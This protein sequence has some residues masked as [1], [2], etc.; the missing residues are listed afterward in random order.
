MILSS[1]LLILAA[2]IWGGGFIATKWTFAAFGPYWS[3]SI[4][5]VIASLFILPFLIY[6]FKLNRDLKFYLWPFIC[7]IVLYFSMQTQTIGLKYT[8][9]AKSGFITT[10][11]AFFTPMILMLIERHRYQKSYWF[12]LKLCLIGIALLCD[13]KLDNFNQG[14]AW[15]LACAFL[16]AF[17][18]IITD[19]IT[20]NYNSVELNGYI[21]LFVSL[22]SLPFA[23]L[24]EG[25]PNL[26]PI[27]TTENFFANSPLFGFII[28][29]IF[30]SN[31]AFSI[32]AYAQKTIVI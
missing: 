11:Y 29:G 27:L 32:Q 24:M 12:L 14:D 23:Y 7:A 30:S 28:L 21:C 13:L 9:V 8:T 31:I 4:R 15:T 5:F 26:A 18:I 22:I 17:Q 1:S 16:F 19:K 10:L 2:M 25:V 20:S 6:R 3:N